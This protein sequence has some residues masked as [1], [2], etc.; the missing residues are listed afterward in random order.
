MFPIFSFFKLEKI[1]SIFHFFSFSLFFYFSSFLSKPKEFPIFKIL[2]LFQN[3]NFHTL[4]PLIPPFSLSSMAGYD[5]PRETPHSPLFLHKTP[6]F[7][8]YFTS[9]TKSKSYINFPLHSI[10]LFFT[11]TRISPHHSLFIS[12]PSN[13]FVRLGS[14][15]ISPRI[16]LV[17]SSSTIFRNSYKASH[18][19]SK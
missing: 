17:V 3:S 4:L 15:A 11:S 19:R 5:R 6:S 8:H 2:I 16:K 12:I 7:L 9:F 10:S 13:H 1:S 18:N 14:S